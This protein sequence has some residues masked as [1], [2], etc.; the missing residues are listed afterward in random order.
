MY[1]TLKRCLYVASYSYAPLALTGLYGAQ[2]VYVVGFFRSEAKC[3]GGQPL[4]SGGR[5]DSSRFLRDYLE[6]AMSLQ[7]STKA[8]LLEKKRI[9]EIRTIF[10][11]VCQR[12][13][14]LGICETIVHGD[15]NRGNILTGV[16]H[17]Q[18]IDWSEAYLGNPLISLQHLLLLNKVESP[19]DVVK[20]GDEVEVKVLRVDAADRKIGLSRK[21]LDQAEPEAGEEEA[22]QSGRP[23]RELRGGTGSGG[24]QLFNMPE[25]PPEEK[26]E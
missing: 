10:E 25:T 5:H 3:L 22:G 16:G 13:E 4:Q 26:Q 6:E 15:M 1:C 14:H 21:R 11:A 20:V 24:G 7:T 18:F 8:P 23:Q 2:A 17:G 19:E 9:Q 12:V